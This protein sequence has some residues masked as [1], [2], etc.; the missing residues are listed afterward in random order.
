[1]GKKGKFESVSDDAVAN[2]SFDFVD[3]GWHSAAYNVLAQCKKAR[4]PKGVIYTYL[5]KISSKKEI[6][7]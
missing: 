7:R 4:Q 2:R 1:M 6:G 3:V 5:S